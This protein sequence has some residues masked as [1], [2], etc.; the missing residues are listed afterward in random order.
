MTPGELDHAADAMAYS[1]M[2]GLIKKK[3]QKRR[4]GDKLIPMTLYCFMVLF[5]TLTLYEVFSKFIEIAAS[6]YHGVIQ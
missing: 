1:I 6:T 5:V 2:S 4:L 3:A